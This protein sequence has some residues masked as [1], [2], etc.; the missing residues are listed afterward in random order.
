MTDNKRPEIEGLDAKA[1]DRLHAIAA[2]TPDGESIPPWGYQVT[3]RVD[4]LRRLCAYALELER[5][6]AALLPMTDYLDGIDLLPC[7]DDT[8]VAAQNTGTL[9]AGQ[10][11]AAQAA[12]EAVKAEEGGGG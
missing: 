3:V 12:R 6:N 2:A 8:P 9:K 4:E 7:P 11:R 10:I 1:R 5:I